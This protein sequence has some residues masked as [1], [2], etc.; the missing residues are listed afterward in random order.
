MGRR[1]ELSI[2][3]YQSG[4]F[5]VMIVDKA[6]GKE[7]TLSGNHK[8]SADEFDFVGRIAPACV[9]TEYERITPE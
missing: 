1:I 2:C 4:D 9:W 6:T 7:L 3:T 8:L 5:D